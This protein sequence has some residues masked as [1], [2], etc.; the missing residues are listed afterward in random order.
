LRDKGADVDW[1]DHNGQTPV[2]YALKAGGE[3]GVRFFVDEGVGLD[4]ADKKGKRL[5]QFAAQKECR[6]KGA[7][8]L[9]VGWGAEELGDKE[10]KAKGKKVGVLKKQDKQ[11]DFKTTK[12]YVLTVLRDGVWQKTTAAD[13]NALQQE[14]P[15][16]AKC[17]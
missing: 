14:F 9:L 6:L 11:Q 5:L 4:R 12:K 2:W 7:V 10:K 17:W 16:I 15:D 8:D 1:V 3:E 13:I